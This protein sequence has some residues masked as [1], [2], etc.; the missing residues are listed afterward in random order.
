MEAQKKMT[1]A[2]LAV[3]E[4]S[5]SFITSRERGNI[6]N[7]NAYLMGAKIIDNPNQGQKVRNYEALT[8][9][10]EGQLREVPLSQSGQV[11]NPYLP[12]LWV[13]VHIHEAE[14]FVEV[15]D[16]ET[17][18]L[19]LLFNRPSHPA[20][21]GLFVKRVTSGED[22]SVKYEKGKVF[23]PVKKASRLSID[24]HGFYIR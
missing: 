13:Q 19:S 18:Y 16:L 11:L 8:V 15:K 2:S 23:L 17:A 12:P 1:N 3:L 20:G 22:L 4:S 6:S 21:Y 5:T 14:A 7:L 10:V 24:R 9:S